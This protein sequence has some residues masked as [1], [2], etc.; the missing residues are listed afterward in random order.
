L[1]SKIE[2]YSRKDIGNFVYASACAMEVN[3][4]V[5]KK[6]KDKNVSNTVL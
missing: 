5:V 3:F 4:L 2:R 6:T 1:E